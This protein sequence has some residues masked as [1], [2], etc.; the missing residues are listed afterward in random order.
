MMIMM[1]MA[2]SFYIPCW[3]LFRLTLKFP[4][5]VFF[6]FFALMDIDQQCLSCLAT[7]ITLSKALESTGY[8]IRK[9][10]KGEKFR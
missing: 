9:F 8:R 6:F 1:W 4:C 10:A 2:L 3:L 5:F 7:E